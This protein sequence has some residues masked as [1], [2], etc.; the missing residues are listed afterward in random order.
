MEPMTA[1][2]NG[3]KSAPVA[4]AVGL[5]PIALA[6]LLVAA[7]VEFQSALRGALPLL[8]RYLVLLVV[9]PLAVALVL[10]RL[11]QPTGYGAVLATANVV[12]F[13][14][15]A[16]PGLALAAVLVVG[17][18]L[19][20]GGVLLRERLHDATIA[21]VMA[22]AVAGLALLLGAVAWCL[23]LPVH[24]GLVYTVFG[25]IAIYLGRR[26]TAL[27][28]G[29]VWS[30]AR[31]LMARHPGTSTLCIAVAGLS[32]VFSWL[33]S[34][35]YDD[36]SG[37]LLMAYQ[38][39][40]S[41]YYRMD[42]STHLGALTPWLNNVLHSVLT[43]IGGVD[44]RPLVGTL[45]LVLGFTGSYR[46]AR[47]LGGSEWAGLTSAVLY[48][49]YPLTAYFGT[50]LQVDAAS[51]AVTFHL[52]AATFDSA[53][54]SERLPAAIAGALMGLLAGLKMT[55]LVFV[56][57]IALVLVWRWGRQGR[58]RDIAVAAAVAAFVA[59]SCYAYAL[60]IT[61]NPV[62]PFYNALFA[63]P[64]MPAE[65]FVDPRWQG[66][67]ELRSIWDIT[68]ATSRFMEA[69]TGA[70]GISLIAFSGAFVLALVGRG[71]Q[72][73]VTLGALAIGLFFFYQVQYLRYLYPVIAVL[74]TV[75]VVVL[76][77]RVGERIAWLAIVAVVVVQCGL[78]RTTSWMFND[79]A[80]DRLLAEGPSVRDDL[81]RQYVPE[82]VLLQRLLYRDR[83]VCILNTSRGAPYI[84]AGAGNAMSTAW[85]DVRMSRAADWAS[86]DVSGARW[87]QVLSSTGV[88][89]VLVRQ[90]ELDAGARR[91]LGA[92]RYRLTDVEGD[93]QLWS[94]PDADALAC[95]Q[96]LFA[97][98]DE[99]RR[100]RAG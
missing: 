9:L 17:A 29:C 32:S 81:E 47:S 57:P 86:R 14:A 23:P 49:S 65:N 13:L 87:K 98:R 94:R 6:L 92:A 37:H 54:R 73:L 63:S 4:W 58:F 48:A 88:S 11:G 45:W 1:A 100:M 74:G 99:A 34:L 38:L 15:F 27:M 95:Q 31:Q 20:I 7:N 59:G 79:G 84:A 89:H 41:G 67:F 28:V 19:S 8:V 40:V 16:G 64:Y 85:Y 72:A 50:T 5:A 61:G 2:S 83:P 43:L 52:L 90:S 46:L 56:A 78:V 18:S 71:R 75:A 80:V 96:R 91:A 62:F 82:R 70:A 22:A 60:F 51:T 93:A 35:N 97:P 30:G 21:Q 33:P 36:N 24:S 66:G 68:F 76:F 42:V 26:R 12:A 77:E 69:Y 3:S 53:G 55:N 44:A 39:K 25:S 10:Q